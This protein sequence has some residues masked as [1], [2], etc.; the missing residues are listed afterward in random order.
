MKAKFHFFVWR[1]RER[2]EMRIESIK[3]RGGKK[4]T[5]KIQKRERREAGSKGYKLLREKFEHHSDG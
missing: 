1:E 5:H 3:I 4:S 2:D